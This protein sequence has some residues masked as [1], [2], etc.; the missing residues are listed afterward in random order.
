[1]APTATTTEHI[2]ASEEEAHES[3]LAD[4]GVCE[5]CGPGGYHYYFCPK[6][7]NYYSPEQE[8]LDDLRQERMSDS[9]WRREAEY[10]RFAD[11]WAA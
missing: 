5:M 1:M 4:L 11:R 7:E 8:M 6:S 9:E 3:W 2:W 10:E